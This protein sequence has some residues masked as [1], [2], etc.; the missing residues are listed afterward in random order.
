MRAWRKKVC[1][2]VPLAGFWLGIFLTACAGPSETGFSD[3]APPS[4]DPS[5][6]PDAVLM[7]DPITAAGNSS[8]YTVNGKSYSVMASSRGYRERGTASWYGLKF[9]GRPT[10]NGE[11]FSVYGATAA[12]RSLPIPSYVRVTNEINGASMVLRVNDRGPFHSE[13]LIDLSYGAAVRLGF[14]D[15][16]TTAVLV[17][18]IEVPGTADFRTGAAGGHQNLQ[19]GA[20]S[21]RSAADTLAQRARAVLAVPVIVEPVPDRQ[22]A[23]F[24]VRA[25][26]F[27]DPDSISGAQRELVGAGL[28]EGRAVP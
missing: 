4:I 28:P 13:R 15:Q 27:A 5:A 2:P 25:G 10:A 8:P 17:E 23:L 18:A 7:P 16:G 14:A 20:F 24:R 1:R 6:V 26:P 19:L 22:P 9:H 12:H 21:S 11:R 3:R